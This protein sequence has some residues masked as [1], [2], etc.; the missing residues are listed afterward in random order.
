MD[1][2]GAMVLFPKTNHHAMAYHVMRDATV[3]P[4]FHVFGIGI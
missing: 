1:S 3:E 2:T 4:A